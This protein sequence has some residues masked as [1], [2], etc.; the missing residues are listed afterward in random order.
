MTW[1]YCDL[2]QF[3]RDGSVSPRTWHGHRR[4]GLR[5]KRYGSIATRVSRSVVR[6]PS[7]LWT[8]RIWH[9]RAEQD[10]QRLV[11]PLRFAD[12]RLDKLMNRAP[13]ARC[14]RSLPYRFRFGAA[15]VCRLRI[16]VTRAREMCSLAATC[17]RADRTTP[18]CRKSGRGMVRQQT[19]ARPIARMECQ[20]SDQLP[21]KFVFFP[22]PGSQFNSIRIRTSS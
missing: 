3:L 11:K 22:D 2:E 6:S 16:C 5:E 19:A 12:R 18:Q 4:L 14:V 8:V 15:P 20:R 21:K 17:A 7:G 9:C 13:T 10:R 1:E